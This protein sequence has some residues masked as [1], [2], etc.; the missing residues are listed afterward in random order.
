M[1]K[2]VI[3]NYTYVIFIVKCEF[4]TNFFF[5]FNLEMRAFFKQERVISSNIF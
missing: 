3:F 5:G 4:V 2:E 1:F